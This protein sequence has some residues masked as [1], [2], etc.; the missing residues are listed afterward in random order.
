MDT[1]IKHLKHTSV[2]F[3]EVESVRLGVAVLSV[4]GLQ[5]FNRAIGGGLNIVIKSGNAGTVLKLKC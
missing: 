5:S 3:C 2:M 1:C 4:L